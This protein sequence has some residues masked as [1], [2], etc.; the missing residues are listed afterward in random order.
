MPAAQQASIDAP[1]KPSRRRKFTDASLSAEQTCLI[2]KSFLRVEPALDLVAQLFFLK[3]FRLDI[4]KAFFT[5]KVYYEASQRTARQGVQQNATWQCRWTYPGKDP[6]RLSRITLEQYE[7]VTVTAAGGKLFVDVT[8]SA[9]AERIAPSA[10]NA[11]ACTEAL[12]PV[13]VSTGVPVSLIQV[14]TR[15]L[16]PAA[17]S[18]APSAE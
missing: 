16:S 11:A 6:P 4:E 8:E 9:A 14:R 12:C 5:T 17:T 2:R 18:C 7:Q 1:K 3:L 15:L 10:R 13:N